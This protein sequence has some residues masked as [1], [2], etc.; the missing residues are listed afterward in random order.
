MKYWNY[1]QK[2]GRVNISQSEYWKLC[3]I[4][5]LYFINSFIFFR[6]GYHTIP[7]MLQLHLH[8]IS[9]DFV[10]P[11][12]KTKRH[13]NSFTTEFFIN[14]RGINMHCLNWKFKVNCLL[15]NI[16]NFLES[17][18]KICPSVASL[19]KLHWWYLSLVFGF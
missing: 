3:E 14:S 6:Y 2:E 10:S 19:T 16:W 17:V 7:S 1:A 4:C 5:D 9:C 12:L 15:A 8:V 11:C 13:W 18:W